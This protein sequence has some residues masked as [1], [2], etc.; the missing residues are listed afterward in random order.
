MN[1]PEDG[2]VIIIDDR[3]EEVLPLIRILSKKRVAVNYFTGE[4]DDLPDTPFND[5]RIIFLDLILE[6]LTGNNEKTII[7]TLAGVVKKVV[8][9]KN[10]PFVLLI[11]TMHPEYVEKVK[12][13]LEKE[14]FMPICI[15]L[16][17]TEYFAET[18]EGKYKFKKHKLRSLKKRMLKELQKTDI[19]KIFLIWEN[20]VHDSASA[21]VNEFSKLV[22]FEDK[23]N[24]NVWN[25]NMKKIFYKLAQAWAGKRLNTGPSSEIIKNSLY[26]F[27]GIFNDVLEKN[28]KNIPLDTSLNFD[29]TTEDVEKKIKGKLNSRLIADLSGSEGLYPGNV[30]R[31]KV[32]KNFLKDILNINDKNQIEK[33]KTKSIGV[34]LEISSPCDFLQEKMRRSR[35]LKGVLLPEKVDEIN[36]WKK[37]KKADF[38]YSIPPIFYKNNLYKMVFDLRYFTATTIKEIEKRRAIFRIRHELLADI[39]RKLSSH[40]N[41]TGVLWLENSKN[42]C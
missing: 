36:V 24:K 25:K 4:V 40:V 6:G 20:L 15:D 33:I 26:T 7:S 39:Q 11:W 19:F 23:W 18:K 16:E 35:L 5:V 31:E 41:R 22:E 14:G 38:V 28:I 37:I 9:D 32:K 17:K 10:G 1:L 29:G 13:T 12:E 42:D 30:Y 8:S 21:T 2:R 27:I 3:V 34:T